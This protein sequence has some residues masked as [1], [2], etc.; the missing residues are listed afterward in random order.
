MCISLGFDNQEHRVVTVMEGLLCARRLHVHF[1][2]HVTNEETE[3]RDS[4]VTCPWVTDNGRPPNVHRE[5]PRA[6]M[7]PSPVLPPVI[8]PP[9]ESQVLPGSPAWHSE[10]AQMQSKKL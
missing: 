10:R 1:L 6:K 2:S 7:T 5:L 9:T 4:S 8:M 3:A